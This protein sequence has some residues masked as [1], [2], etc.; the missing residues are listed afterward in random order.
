M[1]GAAEAKLAA[2]E[3]NDTVLIRSSTLGK[4]LMHRNSKRE[5]EEDEGGG[6]V[7]GGG[8]KKK[9]EVQNRKAVKCATFLPP[10][11][12]VPPLVWSGASPPAETS[13]CDVSS[14]QNPILVPFTKLSGFAPTRQP[15]LLPR[16]KKKQTFEKINHSCV[17]HRTEIRTC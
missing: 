1:T 7:W 2:G 3:R 10:C 13:Q 16:Q 17:I 4:V 5:E 6:C 15:V 14:Q 11:H 9:L 8:E 12:T